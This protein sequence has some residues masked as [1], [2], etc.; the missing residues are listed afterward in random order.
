MSWCPVA[1]LTDEISQDLDTVLRELHRI[2]ALT[3]TT[4]N[5]PAVANG[6]LLVRNGTE[7]VCF[8]VA[9]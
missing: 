9:P 7:A 6:K 4:W 8:D 3:G 5:H 1:I 2:P